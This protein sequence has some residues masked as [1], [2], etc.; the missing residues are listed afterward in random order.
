MPR[1]KQNAYDSTR[2]KVRVRTKTLTERTM[3]WKERAKVEEK[4]RGVSLSLFLSHG[5]VRTAGARPLHDHSRCV[6]NSSSRAVPSLSLSDTFL[7]WESA[8]PGVGP[9]L[10]A[11]ASPLPNLVVIKG[12]PTE[13]PAVTYTPRI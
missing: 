13:L 9:P 1:R 8:S 3:R 5:G 11:R 6:Q 2:T 7:S 4:G 10:C 12:C